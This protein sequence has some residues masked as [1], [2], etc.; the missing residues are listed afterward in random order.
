MTSGEDIRRQPASSAVSNQQNLLLLLQNTSALAGAEH[1]AANSSATARKLARQDS[2][3]RVG[4][5]ADANIES[6][7]F[8][9]FSVQI[10]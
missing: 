7:A 10:P 9:G 2:Q 3:P 6:R 4:G 5:S 1:L 8:Y